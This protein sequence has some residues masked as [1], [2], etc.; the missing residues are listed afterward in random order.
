M[1]IFMNFFSHLYWMKIFPWFHNLVWQ[2]AFFLPYSEGMHFF[3]RKNHISWDKVGVRYFKVPTNFFYPQSDSFHTKRVAQSGNLSSGSSL[4]AKR[5]YP[6]ATERTQNES[7]ISGDLAKSIA[8]ADPFHFLA[9]CLFPSSVTIQF[10]VSKVLTQF[11]KYFLLDLLHLLDRH[12]F[13]PSLS[14]LMTLISWSPDPDPE[15]A[16]DHDPPHLIVT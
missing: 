16:L 1:K 5:W 9:F 10:D 11:A 3:V 13:F 7:W 12:C 2:C 15:V 4:T 14:T 8:P 6:H